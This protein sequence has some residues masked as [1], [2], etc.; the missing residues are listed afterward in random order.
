MEMSRI[1]VIGVIEQGLG[2]AFDRL[3]ELV[4]EHKALRRF[5]G[6]ADVRDDCRYSY[7][8]LVDNVSLLRPE[9]PGEI[10]HLIVESG[11]A[12]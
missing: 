2:C 7:E 3:D 6:H 11:L 1:L 10:N 12:L 5:P 8:R 9:L 4:N